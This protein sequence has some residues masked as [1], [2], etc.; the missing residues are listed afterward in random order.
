[1]WRSTSFCT[2][3]FLNPASPLRGLVN[4]QVNNKSEEL[5]Q[6]TP[7]KFCTD[8]VPAQC[9]SGWLESPLVRLTSFISQLP[10][11]WHLDLQVINSWKLRLY[12]ASVQH[13]HTMRALGQR[14]HVCGQLSYS[15]RKNTQVV[16]PPHVLCQTYSLQLLSCGFTEAHM[17]SSSLLLNSCSGLLLY[18]R[19]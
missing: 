5:P 2:C 13:T 18:L 17:S 8:I 4:L 14:L 11:S 15:M 16:S 19:T 12:S 7:L 10:C 3:Y 9:Y 6:N 1:M